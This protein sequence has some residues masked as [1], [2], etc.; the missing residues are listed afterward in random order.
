MQS[1]RPPA[2]GS[3]SGAWR[4]TSPGFYTT[5]VRL[6]ENAHLKDTLST[7][8]HFSGA[9]SAS[10]AHSSEAAKSVGG[11]E[12]FRRAQREQAE[13]AASTVSLE[14]AIP[15]TF[16][17]AL[18]A[19]AALALAC[20]G[21][22]ALRYRIGRG[23][24]LSRPITEVLFEDQSLHDA[25]AKTVPKGARRPGWAEEAQQLLAKLGVQQEP[26]SPS[27]SDPEALEKAIQ[28]ALQ[29]PNKSDGKSDSKGGDKDKAQGKDGAASDQSANGDPI[30]GGDKSTSNP[31]DGDSP[32]NAKEADG[33]EKTNSSKDG[34]A[35]NESLLSK[36]KDAVSNLLSKSQPD[37]KSPQKGD[38]QQSAK[39]DAHKLEKVKASRR[40]RR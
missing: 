14:A 11:S 17:R 9:H 21:L 7:A 25:K 10:G 27:P 32:A 2:R 35:S 5:A 36:L 30:D 16:P 40:P 26:D 28:Q 34:G 24:D 39:N 33:G 15:F 1:S 20:S 38:Q 13:A 6:D 31:K 19:M 23:L 29:Q 12:R 8:L 22:V 4:A 18:Y 37:Q 3:A